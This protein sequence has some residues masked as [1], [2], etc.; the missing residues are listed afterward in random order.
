MIPPSK[1]QI[2]NKYNSMMNQQTIK[3]NFIK[4]LKYLYLDPKRVMKS[5]IRRIEEIF[6][7]LSLPLMLHFFPSYIY[8]LVNLNEKFMPKKNEKLSLKN[9]LEDNFHYK[10]Q[11]KIYK[12]I[13]IIL[14]GESIKK[15]ITKIN[16]NLP[17]FQVN[18]PKQLVK[19]YNPIHLTTDGGIYYLLVKK[20]KGPVILFRQSCALKK[21]LN[22]EKENKLYINPKKKI[23]KINLKKLNTI[24]KLFCASK[25]GMMLGSAIISIIILGGLASRVNV[26]GWDYFQDE[27]IDKFSY[28]KLLFLLNPKNDHI[29]GDRTQSRVYHESMY[30]WYYAYRLS[31]QK[32]YN[33]I[34]FLSNIKKKIKII[35]K[36][37]K[38]YFK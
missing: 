37:E 15:N 14:R 25:D 23:S 27:E 10:K 12:E 34:S 17:T 28:F 4:K 1:K 38:A 22:L 21:K 6:Y 24:N 36:I 20:T 33:I 9:N 32:K 26:Y 8:L 7:T 31:L 16:F 18:F 29:K 3:N 13:N 19:K 11:K 5:V 2:Q 30:T 35:K